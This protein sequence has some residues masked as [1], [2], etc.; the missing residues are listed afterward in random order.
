MVI[1]WMTLGGADRFNLDLVRLLTAR[2][3]EITIVATLDGD[4]SWAPEFA[5]F[6][7]DIFVLGNFLAAGDQ[8]RFVRY[9][10]DSRK[11]DA[12]LITNSEFGYE[13]LPYL[14]YYHPQL[15]IVDFCHMEEN[16][17]H[18]GGYPRLSVDHGKRLDLTIVSSQHLRG[19]MMARAADPARVAVCYTG[20][21]PEAW[22]RTNV[23]RASVR[24]ELGLAATTSV[25]LY[26]AR[27]C[28]QKQPRV[29]AKTLLRLKTEGMA[30][31]AIVAGDGPDLPWMRHFVRQHALADNVRFIGSV[32]AG[33]MRAIFAAADVLVLPSAWEGISLALY[34]AMAAGLPIVAAAVGGQV[35]LVTSSCGILLPRQL[36]ENSEADAYA[37][38]I[39]EL[40]MDPERRQR[41]S[42]AARA[43]ISEG[44]SL[45]NMADRMV[46]LLA[47]AHKHAITRP[48]SEPLA[49]PATTHRY[50]ALRHHRAH[51]A[52]SP[53]SPLPAPPSSHLYELIRRIGRP[54]FDCGMK[55]GWHWPH[56]LRARLRRAL[57]TA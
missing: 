29:F 3:W 46:S 40:I 32:A 39:A 21:D 10:I 22:R 48:R 26:P 43:R 52:T 45:T 12:V 54:V 8:P 41:M 37:R 27:L 9:L 15:P 23:D 17:W 19:W 31:C 34:E 11:P 30:F 42:L 57:A 50:S 18:N 49:A 13:L 5:R 33:E 7:P 24:Q 47:E 53:T 28:T 55:R 25:L 20:V 56:R 1:P 44:F 4:N 35:E 36:D 51:L 14:R 16:N 6:T 2:G 38:A